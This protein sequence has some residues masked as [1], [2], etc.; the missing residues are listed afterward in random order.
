MHRGRP[1][2][3]APSF[4][5]RPFAGSRCTASSSLGLL[6]QLDPDLAREEDRHETDFDLSET[7]DKSFLGGKSCVHAVENLSQK[8]L[9]LDRWCRDPD[10]R[11]LPLR[12]VFH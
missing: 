2:E 11:Q 3:R 1:G 7:P 8:V 12:D 4:E 5:E 6:L 9:L 10:L